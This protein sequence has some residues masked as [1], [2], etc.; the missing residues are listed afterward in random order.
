M[1]IRKRLTEYGG[2]RRQAGLSA[3]L[4]FYLVR[5]VWKMLDRL[6]VAPKEW[7]LPI[8][9]RGYPHPVFLRPGTS[10]QFVF[11]QV[12]IAREY[13][14]LD[15][16]GILDGHDG[17]NVIVDCGANVGY[18]AVY[19][20]NAFKN[21]RVIAVEPDPDNFALCQKNLAPFG[22]RAEVILAAVWSSRTGLKLRKAAGRENEWGIQVVETSSEEADVQATSL[23]ALI[24]ERGLASIELLKVDI[25]GAERTVFGDK[26]EWLEKVK[27]IVIEL[28]GE[29]CARSFYSALE[30]YRYDLS[31]SGEL[32]VCTNIRHT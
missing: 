11:Q 2:F 24:E 31:T 20:L 19:F 4:R 30:T 29:D 23:T 1:D 3:T 9:I 12:F 14:C 10:D 22:S 15:G 6:G 28:H 17:S 25:E 7:Q 5:K 16:Q 26:V 27:N 18:A 13:A 21:A 32:T 8:A